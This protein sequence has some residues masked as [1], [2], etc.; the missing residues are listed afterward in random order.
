MA[1]GVALDNCLEV[2]LWRS[3]NGFGERYLLQRE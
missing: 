1:V 3:L 2:A